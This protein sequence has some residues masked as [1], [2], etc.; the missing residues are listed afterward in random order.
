MQGLCPFY[1]AHRA[2]EA[3]HVIIVNHALL[4]ADIAAE[5]RVLP[6]Y[7]YLIVDEAHHLETATTDGLS[8]QINRT[9]LERQLKDLGGPNAGLLGQIISNTRDA[10]PPEP[11]MV[12]DRE[13]EY[14]YECA[15]TAMALARQFFEEVTTFLEEQREGNRIGEYTQH[16]RIVPA[17]RTQPH[18]ERLEISW[19]ELREVL[20]ALAESTYRLS[21][22]LTELE[23]YEIEEREDLVS[24][25]GAASRHFGAVVE[26]IHGL[27]LK[28]DPTMIYWAQVQPDGERVSLHA[29]PLH[30]GPLVEKHLWRAKES[31]V[32]ASATLTT[33]GEFNYIKG[34]LNADEADEIAVGSPFDYESSTLLYLVNDMPEPVEKVAY[35]KAIEK[36]LISLCTATRGRALVLF[37]SY[38]GVGG[39]KPTAEAIRDPLTRAGVEVYDQGDGA[40][41]T[42]LLD[43]FKSSEGAV[44]LG[45]KSFWEGVDVPGDALSVLVIVK[46]PFDVPTDPIIAG[47]GETFE[48]P[49]TEYTVPEAVLRFRQGFGRLIRSRSDRGVVAIFDR[50]ILTKNYGRIFLDSL[51]S[52]T[53]KTA[54]LTQLAKEAARW[55]DGG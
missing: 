29:A 3:A 9:D 46:L 1:R 25:A 31:V 49:F 13:V 44:L 21:R 11:F 38:K 17:T 51:P 7:R 12:L 8:F 22:G 41:R 27:I 34:R 42:A 16:V 10:L 24:A 36:G 19:D 18:W 32:M 48:N 30:V 50:R 15:S 52:C 2:A 26:N 55:I 37:T 33:A 23:Q 40:S 28:P 54:P 20:T 35:Q 43:S 6:D 53:V 5:N 45:T 47:R 39:L 4:L 14:A